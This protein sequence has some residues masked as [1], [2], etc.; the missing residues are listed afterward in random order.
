MRS[1]HWVVADRAWIWYCADLLAPVEV[2]VVSTCDISAASVR[3]EPP[4]AAAGARAVRSRRL[5]LGT[6]CRRTSG[7][8]VSLSPKRRM[9][10]ALVS[11]GRRGV[12][13]AGDAL[14]GDA[15]SM[16]LCRITFA[17]VS[18]GSRRRISFGSRALSQLFH[19]IESRE[20]IEVQ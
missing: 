5:A 10:D 14:V 15:V 7:E 1:C 13:G 19:V 20:I 11:W 3:L 16:L 2:Y 18:C 12:G 17:A 9:G 8:L 6:C 4:A